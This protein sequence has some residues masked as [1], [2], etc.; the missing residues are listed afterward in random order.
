MINYSLVSYRNELK[1]RWQDPA[2]FDQ[3]E[4]WLKKKKQQQ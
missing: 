3:P 1:N 2:A 4:K